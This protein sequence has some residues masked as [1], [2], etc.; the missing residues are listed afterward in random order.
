MNKLQSALRYEHRLQEEKSKRVKDLADQA[1]AHQRELLD[2]KIAGAVAIRDKTVEYERKLTDA[3]FVNLAT[4]AEEHRHYHDREHILYENAID[5]AS[6]ALQAQIKV[7]E[8]DVD[9]MRDNSAGYLTRSEW[10]R[11][12]K[13]LSEKT[14]TAIG[15]LRDQVVTEEKV[16]I[17]QDTATQILTQMRTDRTTAFRFQLTIA[18]GL[19]GTFAL[20]FLH[21][22]GVLK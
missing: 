16:T 5:K 7:L 18:V 10:E 6:T 1:I 4:V 9:R 21:I 12:H 8:A 15:V 22:A 14:D 2:E 3:Q 17:R 19:I 13:S 11:E 20:S